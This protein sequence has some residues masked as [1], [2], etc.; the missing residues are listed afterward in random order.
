MGDITSLP[1]EAIIAMFT[2]PNHQA[3]AFRLVE[4]AKMNTRK[5][6]R[7]GQGEAKDGEDRLSDY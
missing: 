7:N 2:H 4:L 3:G 1:H 5:G 6:R